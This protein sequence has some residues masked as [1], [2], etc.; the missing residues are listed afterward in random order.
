PNC[1]RSPRE[2]FPGLPK[3]A[4]FGVLL[5]NASCSKAWLLADPIHDAIGVLDLV[6][7]R[8]NLVVTEPLAAHPPRL[9]HSRVPE[10]TLAR[11]LKLVLVQHLRLVIAAHRSR[12]ASL[13]AK[14][15]CID[16]GE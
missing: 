7:P 2:P 9:R 5:R 15:S 4:A 3:I 11:R 1:W 6:L 16:V 12:P 14:R 8:F 10:L 13:L